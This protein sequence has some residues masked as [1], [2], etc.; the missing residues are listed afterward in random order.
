MVLKN[1]HDDSH[2]WPPIYI[3]TTV[4]YQCTHTHY[5]QPWDYNMCLLHIIVAMSEYVGMGILDHISGVKMELWKLVC[6]LDLLIQTLFSK[7][8]LCGFVL[9]E[10]LGQS[11][12]LGYDHVLRIWMDYNDMC[13]LLRTWLVLLNLTNP[14]DDIL[15]PL[16]LL[17]RDQTLPLLYLQDSS[18]IFFSIL[19][20]IALW[21]EKNF[22]AQLKTGIV[23]L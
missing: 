3:V 17:S 5:P 9:R 4:L 19:Q 15:M 14:S 11:S 20:L 16:D 1:S 2:N 6:I 12:R 21:I 18:T 8:R 10:K 7:D 22:Y 23:R 13:M